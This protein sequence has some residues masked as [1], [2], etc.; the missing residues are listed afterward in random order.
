MSIALIVAAGC[1]AGDV[2]TGDT[3]PSVWL[4][5][6]S[7]S[8]SALPGFESAIPGIVVD[9]AEGRQFSAAP[10]ILGAMLESAPA[11]DVVVIALG[12]NGPVDRA[13]VDAV[14]D[15]AGDA[16]VLFVNVR[17]PRPWEQVSNA[18]IERAA[19]VYGATVIDWKTIADA[20]PE[21][22][23]NDG[24]HLSTRGIAVLVDLVANAVRG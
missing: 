16:E 5:G 21:L 13:D 4:V 9:A 22:L 6:D 17:V 23:A 11:P 2:T 20:D 18:E 15:L 7:I 8:V 3:A 1:A 14:M 19:D 10:S 24:Y 12:T